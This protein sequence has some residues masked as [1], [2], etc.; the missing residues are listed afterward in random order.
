MRQSILFPDGGTD[1]RAAGSLGRIL[2]LTG[3]LDRTRVRTLIGEHDGMITGKDAGPTTL[4]FPFA[5]ANRA[6]RASLE[7]ARVGGV[8]VER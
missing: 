7:V 2:E 3:R 4:T 6:A 8:G 5:D 1:V